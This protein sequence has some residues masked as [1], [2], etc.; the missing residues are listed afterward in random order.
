[1]QIKHEASKEEASGMFRYLISR[2]LPMEI[3]MKVTTNSEHEVKREWNFCR[4]HY[5]GCTYIN[6][7]AW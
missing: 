2:M 3:E 1:M 7:K 5:P 4:C 6:T